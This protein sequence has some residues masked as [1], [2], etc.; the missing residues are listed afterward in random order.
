MN[1]KRSKEVVNG[2]V[3]TVPRNEDVENLPGVACEIR[4]HRWD[5]EERQVCGIIKRKL[6]LGWGR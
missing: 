3:R 5:E 1:V 6:P 2:S 4:K